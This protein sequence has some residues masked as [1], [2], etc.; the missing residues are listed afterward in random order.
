MHF[1]DVGGG[2]DDR[3]WSYEF[4]SYDELIECLH[5]IKFNVPSGTKFSYYAILYDKD[6]HF[7][8]SSTGALSVGVTVTV[9][10]SPHGVNLDRKIQVLDIAYLT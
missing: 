8:E 4:D 9:R 5:K 2:R 3:G 6:L 1:L 10:V 7:S